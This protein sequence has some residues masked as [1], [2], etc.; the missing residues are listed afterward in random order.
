MKHVFISYAREDSKI[1][2]SIAAFLR[3]HGMDVWL[4][5]DSIAPG[6]NWRTAIRLA[7]QNGDYFLYCH[8]SAS[9]AKER[10]YQNEEITLALEELRLRSRSVRWFIPLRLDATAIP[11]LS[12]SSGFE[13][14]DL[15]WIDVFDPFGDP[16]QIL[17]EAI[18]PPSK[19]KAPTRPGQMEFQGSNPWGLFPELR[20]DPIDRRSQSYTHTDDLASWEITFNAVGTAQLRVTTY[21]QKR[22]LL[23]K[24]S[25]PKDSFTFEGRYNDSDGIV[26]MVVG[27][28]NDLL[29]IVAEEPGIYT[30]QEPNGETSS[31]TRT[32]RNA[33]FTFKC[34]LTGTQMRLQVF[35]GPL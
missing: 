18:S 17:L 31:V 24:Y 13:I 1:V 28:G 25:D 21:T 15:Q 9:A 11:D 10:A 23:F 2:D 34:P 4:D 12:I 33:L 3:S 8:S 32:G 29:R 16:L 27:T 19:R 7:V 6:E 35:T 26:T 5:R 14:R 20:N 22:F 30:Y